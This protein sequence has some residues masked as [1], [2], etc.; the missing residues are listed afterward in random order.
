MTDPN[1]KVIVTSGCS[2]TKGEKSWPNHLSLI[3]NK[4]LVNLGKMSAGNG[5]ISRSTIYQILELLKI[6]NNDQLLVGIMWS[7]AS[8]HEIYKEKIDYNKI[9]Q[10][11]T[12]N[13]ISFIDDE[14]WTILNHHWTDYY[15]RNYYSSF[16]DEIFSYVITLE[17]ILRTQW[18]L[19]RKKIKYFMT[20]FAP[21]VLPEKEKQDHPSLQHLYDMI[22][23][24]RFLPV[25]SCIDWCI[26]S[27]IPCEDDDNL[28]LWARHPSDEQ[29][30]K[31]TEN[32]IIPF[33]N[34][35]ESYE[36]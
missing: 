1:I 20:T 5:Y 30:K 24:S 27:N 35:K 36:K 6:Y 28:S 9:N 8:R 14:H 19:D 32:V 29:Q 7:G 34:Q 22:N 26:E 31:F 17:H 23:W 4:D 10:Q 21:S 15:S 25:N 16:Y 3:L 2:F 13:P 33:L 12:E 11:G 18:F